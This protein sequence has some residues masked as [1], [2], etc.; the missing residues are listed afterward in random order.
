MGKTD[1]VMSSTRPRLIVPAGFLRRPG[2][3]L[4]GLRAAFDMVEADSPESI[5]P[6][7]DTLMLWPQGPPPPDSGVEGMSADSVMATLQHIGEGVGLVDAR[8]ELTWANNRLLSYDNATRRC[9]AETCRG[10]MEQFDQTGARAVA[11]NARPSR[12]FA[13]AVDRAHFEVLVSIASVDASEDSC[14]RRVVGILWEVTAARELQAKIDAIDAAGSELMRIDN[15]VIE[16]LNMG[17]RLSLLEEKIIRYVRELLNFDK[18]EVRIV[19]RETNQ[20]ELVFNRGLTPLRIGEALYADKENNGISGY[21]A[22]TG[23]PY[24]CEDSAE[25]PFYWP[26]LDGARSALTVPLRLYDR[27]IGVFNV[28]SARP[29][30]FT[31]HDRRFA[32]IFARYI[33]MAMHILDLLVVERYTTNEQIAAN[34]LGE[35]TEPLEEITAEAAALRRKLAKGTSTG[36][37]DRIIQAAEGIRRRVLVCTSGPKSILGAEQTLARI[38]LDPLMDGKRV[39]LAENEQGIR[40]VIRE[41]LTRKGCDVTVCED[42]A[43]A[44]ELLLAAHAEG[45]AYDLVISDVKMPDRNGYEVFR[46]AKECAP[47][48]PV[49]LMTGFGY[50]PHHSIVRASQ[51]GLHSFLFKPLTA[52]QLLKAVEK[53]LT[54]VK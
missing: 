27:V 35:L 32:Q 42:G 19:D 5:A 8:G 53:A 49:I 10:A 12:K 21:V 2:P 18:F 48:T 13:F 4:E 7:D 24:I 20:L 25:D 38:E 9:F 39:I 6:S 26:G 37:L 51:E 41:L 30:A 28:E 50:D 43:Q 23:E 54:G 3:H 36:E 15:T 22:A 33:A 40:D 31:E 52:E 11:L 45:R 16:K 1:R 46:T 34:V 14:V 29:H 44:I 17:E 47:E